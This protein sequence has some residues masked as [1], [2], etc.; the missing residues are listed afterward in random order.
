MKGPTAGEETLS[1]AEML[2]E[3]LTDQARGRAAELRERLER[4]GIPVVYTRASGAVTLTLRQHRWVASAPNGWSL[5]GG[6]ER[7]RR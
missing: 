5:T 3:R 1:E 7:G 4:R 6:T 2:G